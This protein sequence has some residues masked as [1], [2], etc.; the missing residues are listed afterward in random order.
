MNGWDWLDAAAPGPRRWLIALTAV[1]LMVGTLLLD[2]MH[3][4]VQV[5]DAISLAW[6]GA[7]ALLWG[8]LRWR[9]TPHLRAQ[10]RGEQARRLRR[11]ERRALL[12]GG[13]LLDDHGGLHA[14]RHRDHAFSES[15]LVSPKKTR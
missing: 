1:S 2:R 9:T 3:L 5:V 8:L 12:V 10:Q 14:L 13:A 7:L 11:R 15:A 4:T 6:L